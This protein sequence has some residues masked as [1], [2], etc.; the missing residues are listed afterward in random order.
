MNRNRR[1]L[2]AVLVA[3]GAVVYGLSPID[4]IPELLAGPFGILDDLGVLGAAGW[5]VY[6]LLRGRP[7]VGPNPQ[8]PPA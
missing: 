4:I 6:R 1:V 8:Q 5:G 3:L 7:D 2:A